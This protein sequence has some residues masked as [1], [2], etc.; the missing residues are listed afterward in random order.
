MFF[1]D[2]EHTW[3]HLSQFEADLGEFFASKGFEAQVVPTVDEKNS[4]RILF[5]TRQ[6]LLDTMRT[7]NKEHKPGDFKKDLDRLRSAEYYNQG[8]QKPK[9]EKK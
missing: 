6:Q 8:K 4:R 9:K 5:I 2:P 1:F 7:D 3:Q